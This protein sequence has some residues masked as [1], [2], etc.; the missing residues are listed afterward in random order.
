[1]RGL[2]HSKGFNIGIVFKDCVIA[3]DDLTGILDGT[4]QFKA[5][6]PIALP[7][8]WE[9]VSGQQRSFMH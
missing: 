8:N 4:P 6:L 2:K 7:A 3:S 5:N 1:M 9:T